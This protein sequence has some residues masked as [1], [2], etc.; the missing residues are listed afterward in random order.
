M[1]DNLSN[2]LPLHYVWLNP[3]DFSR[4]SDFTLGS[5]WAPWTP[6]PDGAYA[7]PPLA[8]TVTDSVLPSD[9]APLAN[10]YWSTSADEDE[11]E[12]WIQGDTLPQT[13]V[14]DFWSAHAPATAL[15]QPG[16]GPAF[17][18]TFTNVEQVCPDCGHLKG[19]AGDVHSAAGCVVTLTT[20][21]RVCVVPVVGQGA[22]LSGGEKAQRAI[23]LT[24]ALR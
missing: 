2:D 8:V 6:S 7:S 20:G 14:Q 24:G 11:H 12:T 17:A 5:A 15:L 4:A 23:R 21:K 9:S 22:G 1:A 18:V 19:R 16:A 3:D 13:L 10:W